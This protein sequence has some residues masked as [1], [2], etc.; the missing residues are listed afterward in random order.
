MVVKKRRRFKPADKLR[1]VLSGLSGEERV[2]DICRCEGIST[3]QLL[4]QRSIMRISYRN[5]RKK[6][7]Q[8]CLT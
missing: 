4:L 1:I 7:W 3:V 5:T 6:L 8:N 2:S